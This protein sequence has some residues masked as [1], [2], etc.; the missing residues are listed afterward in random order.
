MRTRESFLTLIAEL[1]GDYR[2]LGRIMAQNLRAWGRIRNGARLIRWTGE[3]SV[4]P[5]I[6][7]MECSRTIF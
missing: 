6:P 5:F 7:P 2:E 3:L 4:S 1:E